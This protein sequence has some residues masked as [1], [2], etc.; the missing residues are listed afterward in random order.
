MSDRDSPRV[1]IPPPAIIIGTLLVGLGIDGR[2]AVAP[3]PMLIP[4]TIG[5]GISILGLS[6][7]AAALGRFHRVGTRAEPWQPSKVLVRNGVFR[8]TRNP[9][10]L[11]MLLVYAGIALALQSVAAGA[12]LI[13]LWLMI[14]RTVV[15][16]E[17][18][19]LLRRFG[20]AFREYRAEV[21]RWL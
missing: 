14:D 4:T 19:Y 1:F 3:E 16:R 10:Y 7:I 12:L 5:V 17:E 8:F 2:L 20:S 13:P 11:G 15:K 18:Q 9:M 6:L 21:R